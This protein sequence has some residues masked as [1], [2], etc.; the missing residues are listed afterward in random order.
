MSIEMSP[1]V[2]MENLTYTQISS[3][4]DSFCHADDRKHLSVKILH[5]ATLRSE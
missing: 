5:S 4:C 1:I 3:N 2:N